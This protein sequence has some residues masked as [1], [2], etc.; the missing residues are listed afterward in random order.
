MGN[1]KKVIKLYQKM[2]TFKETNYLKTFAN[3]SMTKIRQPSYKACIENYKGREMK[4]SK[5]CLDISLR[6][7]NIINAKGNDD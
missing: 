4:I 6:K 7:K 3:L 1:G 5:Y 2:P